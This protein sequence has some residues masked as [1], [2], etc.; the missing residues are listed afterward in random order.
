MIELNLINTLERVKIDG[1]YIVKAKEIKKSKSS[2]EPI[3]RKYFLPRMVIYV[4]TA[5]PT[6][7]FIPV[8]K[9]LIANFC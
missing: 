4:K 7:E 6:R 3:F 8:M 1:V 5:H 9:G 2:S